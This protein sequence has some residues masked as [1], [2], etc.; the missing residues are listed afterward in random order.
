MAITL[1]DQT[2][3]FSAVI[4]LQ[5]ETAHSAC[6]RNTSMIPNVGSQQGSWSDMW[7]CVSGG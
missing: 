3:P 5:S 4:I 2:V 6:Q 7:L 1:N